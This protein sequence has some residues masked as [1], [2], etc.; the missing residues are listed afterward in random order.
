MSRSL[1]HLGGISLAIV[2]VDGE[3]VELDA[4]E[5]GGHHS[6]D[7]PVEFLGVERERLRTRGREKI[8]GKKQTTASSVEGE[9]R[10]GPPPKKKDKILSTDYDDE[11]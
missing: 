9:R 2:L 10:E 8:G 6:L 5:L 1:S 7:G 11:A 3:H 4:A